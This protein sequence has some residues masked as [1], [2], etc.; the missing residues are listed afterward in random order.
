M[1]ISELNKNAWGSIA[2]FLEQ[3]HP[4]AQSSKTCKKIAEDSF[5]PA[6][7]NAYMKLG[8]VRF[9][10]DNLGEDLSAVEKVR[11][12]YLRI[13]EEMKARG[14]GEAILDGFHR[15]RSLHPSKL[16]SLALINRGNRDNNLDDAFK[17]IAIELPAAATFLAGLLSRCSSKPHPRLDEQK[18]PGALQGYKFPLAI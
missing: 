8:H 14:G 10:T 4:F 17:R 2:L 15:P 5:Y 6:F 11:T 7:F 1:S 13:V 18:S 3:L 16:N 9:F 12:V